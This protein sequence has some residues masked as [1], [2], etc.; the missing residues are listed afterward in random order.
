MQVQGFVVRETEAAVAFVSQADAGKDGVRPL[1]VPRRKILAASELDL[2]G[3][4]IRTAQDG[5]RIGLPF[6]LTVEDEFAAKVK[7]AA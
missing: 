4:T 3:V 1:W 5:E 6:S 7:L 2:M